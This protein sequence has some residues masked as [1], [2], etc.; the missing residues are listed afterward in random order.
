MTKGFPVYIL[1]LLLS[2][3]LVVP[4]GGTPVSR[5]APKSTHDGTILYVGGSGP[6]N[7][8]T[9]Q[10]AIDAAAN[11]DTVYVY[12]DASPYHENIVISHAISI[13]GERRETTVIDGTGLFLDIVTVTADDVTIR[14][15]TVQSS[16]CSGV[17]IQAS[18]ALVDSVTVQNCHNIGVDLSRTG[19]SPLEANVVTDSTIANN[20]LGIHLWI[21]N[22]TL[23]T[24]NLIFHNSL[25]I[26]IEYSFNDNV[27]LNLIRS[28]TDGIQ[29]WY[30][31][32]ISIYKNNI[33]E[34]N[35][36]IEE[37]C[38]CGNYVIANN[39]NNDGMYARF[40]RSWDEIKALQDASQYHN[41]YFLDNFEI[42]SLT[43][44]DANYWGS[45]V[46]IYPIFGYNDYI[47]WLPLLAK[48]RIR[49]DW[50]PAQVPYDIP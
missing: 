3:S 44:W 41:Y 22:R 30:S 39:F 31:G 1:L 36:G 34:A 5:T 17:L 20:S 16:P 42:F 35:M 25:G 10:N 13:V 11:G 8:T 38:S 27:S 47:D 32:A 24:R 15:L 49:V 6:G 26:K 7:Y 40:T 14:N 43:S 29:A 4:S 46:S 12:D 45:P 18:G 33:S 9:I 2:C 50:H 21:C 48:L 28:N 37:I 19:F 23:V